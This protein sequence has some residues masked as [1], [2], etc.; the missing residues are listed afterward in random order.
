MSLKRRTV[1]SME[2]ALS[3][4]SATLR[5]VHLGWRVIRIEAA[6]VPG[7]GLPGDPNRYIGST[8]ADSDRRSY[9]LAPN[10]G[11]E[12]IA[13]NL[14]DPKSHE[15]LKRLIRELDVEIF[16]CNT[17]PGRYRQ[18]GIS[19]EQL[20]EA[21]PD[22]I[23]AGIS[24]MGPDYPDVPG[25]DPVIQALSGY[26]E[27]TGDPNGP[28]TLA[29]VPI[30]DLKA[31]DE[32]YAGVLLALAE[33]AETGQGKRIDISM[34]QAA[35]SWLITTLPLLDMNCDPAEIGRAG[36][37]HRKFVPT[38]AYPAQDGFIYIAI[39]SDGQ[40]KKFTELAKFAPT[41]RPDRA[42]NEGRTRDRDNV[43]ADIA[44]QSVKYKAKDIAEDLAKA[45]IAHSLINTV[46]QT[47]AMK[48]VESKLTATRTPDGK[49][50][51]MQP[52]AVDMAGT[53]QDFAF[54]PSYGAQTRA[55]LKEAGY[56]DQE[57]AAL[58]QDGVAHQGDKTQ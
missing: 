35:A 21:R 39:G 45:G 53:P 48:A 2:Q 1:L 19:Y 7:G 14:K 43:I 4:P 22:I 40:W 42:T 30:T 38:N 46:P 15:V 9:F 37:Q 16:C 34:L 58:L 10:V 33:K 11:K 26:M 8:V 52:K 6:P 12:S 49:T 24:A 56:S 5:M 18:L 44:A 17:L 28:P 20:K 25:Y 47:R 23:W 55:I 50:I 29:G 36:N 41:A 32:A 31:G 51:H 27:I 57:T 54:P 3:L 13:L